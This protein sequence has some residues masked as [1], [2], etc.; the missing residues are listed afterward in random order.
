METKDLFSDIIDLKI[1]IENLENELNDLK[2]VKSK[3]S[4][5]YKLDSDCGFINMHDIWIQW[6]KIDFNHPNNIKI[7]FP[8]T[9]NNECFNIQVTNIDGDVIVEEVDRFG[10]TVKKLNK[11]GLLDNNIKA[12]V[13]AIG[14]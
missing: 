5:I 11:D 8:S 13:L 6:K 1:K 14:N 10:F 3:S 2:K 4:E 12:Y 9:F 7:L